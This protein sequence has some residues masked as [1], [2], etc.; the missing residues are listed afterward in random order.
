MAPVPS[1]GKGAARGLKEIARVKEAV[2]VMVSGPKAPH[3]MASV[4]PKAA[5][6]MG[7]AGPKVA[8]AMANAGL[9][10]VRVKEMAEVH[11]ARN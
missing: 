4:D 2:H 6:A 3:A 9:K 7:N 5:R 10:V 8:R 11:S 1:C